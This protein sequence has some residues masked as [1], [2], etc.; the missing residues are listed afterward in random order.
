LTVDSDVLVL[1]FIMGVDLYFQC[2]DW[3]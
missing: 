1:V 2:L 3:A